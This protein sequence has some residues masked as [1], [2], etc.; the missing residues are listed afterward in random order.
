MFASGVGVAAAFTRPVLI[1]T[2]RQSGKIETDC[3][4]YVLVNSQGWILTAAHV[5]GAQVKCNEDKGKY[6][7]YCAARAAIESDT[8]LT[9]GYRKQR[10]NA[11]EVD[12]D[13]ITNVSY[14]WGSSTTVASGLWHLDGLADLGVVKLENHNWPGDQ[15]FAKFGDPAVELPQGQSLCKLGFPFHEFKTTFDETNG[16]FVINEF[17][18]L[19][20]YPL[21]G[22]VTRY[23]SVQAPDGSRSVK[24][25]EM[26]TPGLKGQ[27]GGPWFDVCGTV[28]GIQS[29]TH[30]LRLG[31]TPEV[32]VKSKKVTEHQFLNVGAASYISEIV[33]FLNQ[34]NVP[35]ERA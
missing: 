24:F 12:P 34:H 29:R 3:G 8:S 19:V 1:S 15:K 26:S 23:N 31:F 14:W 30:S 11:L 10:L 28:W 9:K 18:P 21:D 27:S 5:A 32:Q 2:R 35:F 25:V 7:A 22:I 6:D 20:R 17:P 33:R 4:S 16:R 13:W